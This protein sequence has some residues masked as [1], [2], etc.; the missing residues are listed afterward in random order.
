[1]EPLTALIYCSLGASGGFAA[2][3]AV[4]ARMRLVRPKRVSPDKEVIESVRWKREE[5]L[6]LE[7]VRLEDKTP[8]DMKTLFNFKISSIAFAQGERAKIANMMIEDMAIDAVF[9]NMRTGNIREVVI[10]PNNPNLREILYVM[11]RIGV[12]IRSPSS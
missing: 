2:G 1:M 6:D 8:G 11:R 3:V 4:Q 7:I 10:M 12:P 5:N 9:V